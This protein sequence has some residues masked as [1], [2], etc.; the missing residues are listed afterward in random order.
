M[1]SL[2]LFFPLG[3]CPVLLIGAGPVAAAKRRLLARAGA[4]IV[5]EEREGARLA[6]VALEPGDPRTEGIATGLRAQGVL[7]NVADRSDLC[8]FLLP[9]IVDRDPVIVAIGTGGASAGLA[10]ALRQR[11]EGLLP[12]ALGRLAAALHEAR[13]ALAERLPES[14]ARRRAIAA[15]LAAGGAL[16]PMTDH[17]DPDPI[18]ALEAVPRDRIERIVLTSSDPDELTLRAARLLGQADRLYLAAGVPAAI[19]NRARADA[20]RIVGPAP[21]L[22]PPGLSVALVW[23]TE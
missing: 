13:P 4:T 3:S 16:D 8:D 19:A 17:A 1:R 11:L 21:A 7:V 2:P 23:E 5:S 6:F 12:A 9:A 22:A 20:E 14:G 15:L 10:A 18:A